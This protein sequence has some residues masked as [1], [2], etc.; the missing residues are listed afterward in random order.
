MILLPMDS[1]QDI[2]TTPGELFAKFQTG[3]LRRPVGCCV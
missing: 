1:V 2:P 3:V